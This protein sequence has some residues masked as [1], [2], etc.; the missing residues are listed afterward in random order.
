[1]VRLICTAKTGAVGVITSKSEFG[2]APTQFGE[3][4]TEFWWNEKDINAD[5]ALPACSY[6][7][8]SN[9]LFRQIHFYFC[10]VESGLRQIHF[11]LCHIILYIYFS[12]RNSKATLQLHKNRSQV[13]KG[14]CSVE[15]AFFWEGRVTVCS[16]MLQLIVCVVFMC[17]LIG[18]TSLFI[19]ILTG[20]NCW[21]TLAK[22]VLIFVC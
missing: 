3:N 15:I 9:F 17:W 8:K 20:N 16:M 2:A 11:R 5:R 14:S 22:K 12:R 18:C 7:A 21:K 19:A 13:F 4:E 10:Q 6:I 1:M